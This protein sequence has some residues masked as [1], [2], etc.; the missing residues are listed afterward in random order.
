MKSEVCVSN[1]YDLIGSAG[2]CY[3]VCLSLA[4]HN[5]NNNTTL[6]HLQHDDLSTRKKSDPHFFKR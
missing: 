6:H 1:R 2:A 4:H 5:H 3:G